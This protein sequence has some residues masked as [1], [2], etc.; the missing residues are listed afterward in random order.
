MS[1]RKHISHEADR[2]QN[3]KSNWDQV[4]LTEKQ[5][6]DNHF[7]HQST[8]YFRAILHIFWGH[9]YNSRGPRFSALSLYL[10]SKGVFDVGE[11]LEATTTTADVVFVTPNCNDARRSFRHIDRVEVVWI[12]FICNQ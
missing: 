1:I 11:K 3:E 10:G 4:C 2:W 12:D 7:G 6:T 9:G 8:T 5:S